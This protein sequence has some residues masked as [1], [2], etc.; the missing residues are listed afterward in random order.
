ME[1]DNPI[2]GLRLCVVAEVCYLDCWYIPGSSLVIGPR[3]YLER[4]GWTNKS[5]NGELEQF[6]T[7]FGSSGLCKRCCLSGVKYCWLEIG[8]FYGIKSVRFYEV[9]CFLLTL[10]V[11][12]IDFPAFRGSGRISWSNEKPCKQHGHPSWPTQQARASSKV[13]QT[14]RHYQR[15][16]WN[17]GRSGGFYLKVAQ[18]LD[19]YVWIH[20]R[21][22]L[23]WIYRPSQNTSSLPLKGNWIMGRSRCFCG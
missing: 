1:F 10:I 15:I 8:E 12:L 5:G 19:A 18:K 23:R 16:S 6:P 11:W 4:A 13:Q 14:G 7:Y 21:W 3:L 22:I 9:G 2:Q 17:G 20:L